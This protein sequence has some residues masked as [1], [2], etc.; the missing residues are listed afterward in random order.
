MLFISATAALGL[1]NLQRRLLDWP[2]DTRGDG[3]TEPGVAEGPVT[4]SES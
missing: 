4:T 2:P 3:D 1:Q